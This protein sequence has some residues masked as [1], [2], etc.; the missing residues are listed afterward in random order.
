MRLLLLF[1]LLLLPLC[2]GAVQRIEIVDRHDVLDGAPMG[3]AGPYERISAKV[4]FTIDP[5]LPANKIIADVELAPRNEKGL[6]EFSADLYILKPRD[7]AKGNGTALVEISN[8]GG[9]GLLSMFDLAQGSTDARA[10]AE[11]GDNFLLEHGFT[12]VWVGWEF[13]IPPSPKLLHLYAPIASDHEKPIYGLVRS[14][15]EGDQRVTTI[16]LGDR[17]Q[18]AYPV[19]DQ[20]NSAN[21]M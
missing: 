15:W 4:H 14:E 17:T 2:F 6:V 9:K 19:A 1:S 3:D 20:N 7:S 16:S 12:M 8:R 21:K 11:F 10:Q 13:D 18:V 5:N